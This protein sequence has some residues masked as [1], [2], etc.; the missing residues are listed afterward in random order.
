[1]I[2]P[3]TKKSPVGETGQKGVKKHNEHYLQVSIQYTQL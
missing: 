1:M 3:E 2:N